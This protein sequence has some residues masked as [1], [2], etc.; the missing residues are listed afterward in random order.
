[1]RNNAKN[2]GQTFVEYTLMIG[3]SIAILLALVPM[4]KRGTQGMVKVVADELGVQ[5]NAEQKNDGSGGLM[6]S[7]VTAMSDR[8][9]RRQ[10]WQASPTEHRDQTTYNEIG[11]TD[12]HSATDLGF[13]KKE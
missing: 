9:K 4:I 8:G 12:I 3:V 10:E 11:T 2:S 5:Q 7:V 13:T 6:T 1:M